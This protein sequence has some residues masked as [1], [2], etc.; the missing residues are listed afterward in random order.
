M[1]SGECKDSSLPDMQMLTDGHV[2]SSKKVSSTT[3]S[4]VKGMSKYI[5]WEDE[6]KCL[7][8]PDFIQQLGS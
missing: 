1:D 8:S 6:L 3:P 4:K 5:D 7:E 2:S